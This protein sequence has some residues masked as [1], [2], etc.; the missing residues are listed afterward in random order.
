MAKKRSFLIEILLVEG[1]DHEGRREADKFRQDRNDGF[2]QA[3]EVAE[4]G[5]G[6]WGQWRNGE[7][8]KRR[9]EISVSPLLPFSASPA[10]VLPNTGSEL[11]GVVLAT[12]RG[13]IAGAATGMRFW[14]T[15]LV[16]HLR[17]QA[18][19]AVFVE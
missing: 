17:G 19:N 11:A 7:G 14:T 2:R 15:P 6:E 1:L 18:A 3:P 10:L 13:G 8:E 4:K 16:P 12:S 5:R 9:S